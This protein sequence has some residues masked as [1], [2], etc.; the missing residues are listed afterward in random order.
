MNFDNGQDIRV[1]KTKEL[2]LLPVG[3][4]VNLNWA[5][6]G[7]SSQPGVGDTV[8]L[9]SGMGSLQFAL[10]VSKANAHYHHSLM[11]FQNIQVVVTANLQTVGSDN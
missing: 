3:E 2:S 4:V 7:V 1:L 8:L 5:N 11:E 10:I 9:Q 6:L